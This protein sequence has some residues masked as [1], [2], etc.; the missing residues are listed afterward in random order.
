MLAVVAT[1]AVGTYPCA[2]AVS[3]DSARAYVANLDS[4]LAVI[5]TA[6]NTV[7]DTIPVGHYPCAVAVGTD[8][9][10]LYVTNQNDHTVSVIDTTTTPATVS[11]T[12]PVGDFPDTV[13]VS[14]NG[15]HL[16]VTNRFD[17][18]LSVIDIN[19]SSPTY[20]AVTA[21][22][23]VGDFPVAVAVSRDGTHAYVTNGDNAVSV[24]NT[25]SNTVTNSIPVGGFPFAVAVSPDGTH[26]YV[27]NAT[28]STVTVIDI[29][30]SSPTYNAVTATIPV[31][32]A[33]LGVA[34]SPDGTHLYVTNA[35]VT[36]GDA[37]TVSVIDID[38][39]SA[40]YNTVTE[41]V[42]VGTLPSNAYPLDVA[43]SPDGTH[44]YVT[45]AGDNTVSVIADAPSWRWPDYLV[46][47]LL[48][49][50]AAG[51]GGWLV[52]GNHFYKIPPHPLAMAIIA[53]AAAPHLRSPI[54]N[55]ELGEQL[56]EMLS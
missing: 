32:P 39:N 22:I 21:T 20:T 23:P 46:G 4:G 53:R 56:R 49:G 51:G 47:E 35:G 33:P 5:N 19:P 27:T 31:G 2:V 15:T 34:V 50:V 38:P 16:Y 18:T 41:S 6:T 10:H 3:P 7:I 42:P 28:A 54:E 43:V 12:I 45:N 55:R 9:T 36:T 37:G 40:T 29:N 24:I 44:V 11:A 52:I 48:G 25:A 1:I 26:L 17:T 8:G 30:P 13:A 14:P